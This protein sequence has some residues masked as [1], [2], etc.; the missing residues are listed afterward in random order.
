MSVTDL[1]KFDDY[2]G[3]KFDDDC[4]KTSFG[5]ISIRFYE[6]GVPFGILKSWDEPQCS[7][8]EDKL[9]SIQFK[10]INP[11]SRV[12]QALASKGLSLSLKALI[13]RTYPHFIINLKTTKIKLNSGCHHVP[14]HK[15]KVVS[16]TSENKGVIRE[17]E[18]YRGLMKVIN[19]KNSM[20]DLALKMRDGLFFPYV[21]SE[22][23][24]LDVTNLEPVT[25]KN[26]HQLSIS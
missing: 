8:L 3:L 2:F 4:Y 10:T 18:V 11:G 17:F 6:T 7:L 1:L 9:C 25:F 19:E 5:S 16:M 26:K 22:F 13:G 12:G 15:W 21:L 23:E 14:G 24:E 20:K